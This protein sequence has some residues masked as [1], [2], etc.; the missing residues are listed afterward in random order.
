MLINSVTMYLSKYKKEK[1]MKE[2]SKKE[3]ISYIN[4]ILEQLDIEIIIKIYLFI[5]TRYSK[6]ILHKK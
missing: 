4:E 1:A 6:E 3:V 5:T 2:T